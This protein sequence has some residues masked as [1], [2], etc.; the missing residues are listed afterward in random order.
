MA[1][2][3]IDTVALYSSLDGARAARNLL[4]R[5]L[6][7][8]IGVS[9]SLL[10]RLGN[11]LKP[12]ADGFATLVAWLNL[13]AERFIISGEAEQ[14]ADQQPELLAEIAPLLRARKDLSASDVTYLE[15]VIEATVEHMRNRT[16]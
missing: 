4:W 9:P 8:E 5:S 7:K 6:A 15:Q 3:R 14:P 16:D 13:P 11:G 2:A 12:D 1:R 10:S